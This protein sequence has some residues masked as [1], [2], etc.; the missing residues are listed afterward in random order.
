MVALG[1]VLVFGLAFLRLS[2]ALPIIGLA[3]MLAYLLTPLANFFENRVLAVGPLKNRSRR[4]IAVFLTYVL[5]AGLFIILILVVVPAIIQQ[6]EDFTRALPSLMRSLEQTLERFLNEPVTFNGELVLINGKPLIPLERLREITGVKHLTEVIQLQDLNLVGATQTF[7]TSL[8]APAFNFVGGALTT[9]VNLIL[10]F[11]MMFFL[12]RDGSLFIDKGVELTPPVYRGDVR[13]LLYE[14][15]RVWNA[16]LRGQMN[17]SLFMGLASFVAA[18]LLGIR[19]PIVLAITSALLE[20]IPSVGSGLAIFPA[21]L[22]ALSSESLTISHLE[23]VSFMLVAVVTWA[24]LQNIEAIILVPRVMGS[25]LNLHPFVVIVALI[26][27]ASIGGVLG[28]VVAAPTVASLRVFGQYI[29]GKL[30]DQDPFPVHPTRVS[31][32]RFS[33]RMLRR[34]WISLTQPLSTGRLGEQLRA[35]VEALRNQNHV[36]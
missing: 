12:I 6:I 17:L 25:S 10:L 34:A 30:L 36:R 1:A 28:I 27:G 13:R 33:R 16:Y 19:N 18:T 24:I 8:T 29:Y 15:G 20:F 7:I 3:I 2:D 31:R 35:R 22:L 9:L 32:R 14:L 23:G 11:S 26:A 5:L 4:G 21:A